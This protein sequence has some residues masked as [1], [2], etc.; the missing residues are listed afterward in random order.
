M[1]SNSRIGPAPAVR[2]SR[3]QRAPTKRQD[4]ALPPAPGRSTTGTRTSTAAAAPDAGYPAADCRPP[5]PHVDGLLHARPAQQAR[6]AEYEP[7]HDELV[8]AA[9]ALEA[10]GRDV[11]VGRALAD[12]QRLREAEAPVALAAGGGRGAAL[13]AAGQPCWGGGALYIT[14]AQQGVLLAVL[15]VTV[16]VVDWVWVW[17]GGALGWGLVLRGGPRWGAA[18]GGLGFDFYDCA[19]GE[20][21][22]FAECRRCCVRRCRVSLMGSSKRGKPASAV[23]GCMD[24]LTRCDRQGGEGAKQK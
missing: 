4:P 7:P 1:P 20:A 24:S 23:D 13:C 12:G 3:A 14:A 17:V 15:C 9:V 5:G 6:G 2:P 8:L 21:G 18:C 10:H 22:A 11:L 16:V 19:V